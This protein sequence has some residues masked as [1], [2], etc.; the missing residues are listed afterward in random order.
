MKMQNSEPDGQ[1]GKAA[2]RDSGVH[3]RS[4]GGNGGLPLCGI[5][6][7]YQAMLRVRAVCRFIDPPSGALLYKNDCEDVSKAA[8]LIAAACTCRL[9]SVIDSALSVPGRM[10][11]DSG[12]FIGMADA[13]AVM[14]ESPLSREENEA[15]ESM[16]DFD[17][18]L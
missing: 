7:E 16:S 18:D 5:L 17:F 11:A 9:T 12:D 15:L 3:R 10:A 2:R 1:K 4:A 13:A 14:L 8:E 6:P